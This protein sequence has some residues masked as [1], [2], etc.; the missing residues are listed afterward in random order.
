ML[1]AKSTNNVPQRIL[2]LGSYGRAG[3]EIANL[4]LSHTPSGQC[5]SRY[6]NSD[7]GCSEANSSRT[8]PASLV[9]I[10]GS[11]SCAW[12]VDGDC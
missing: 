8:N 10:Y 3:Y 9:E 6:G 7:G 5:L 4:L 1:S 11:G 2:I 12:T